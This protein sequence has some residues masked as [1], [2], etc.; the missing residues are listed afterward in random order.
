[1]GSST[2]AKA[3]PTER[4]TLYHAEVATTFPSDRCLTTS[5]AADEMWNKALS[6][7]SN[8]SCQNVGHGTK[9]LALTSSMGEKQGTEK[10]R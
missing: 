5:Y 3:S 6:I 10:T 4:D 1:M 9:T 2:K 8:V 7:T